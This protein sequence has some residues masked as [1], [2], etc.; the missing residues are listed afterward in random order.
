MTN[1]DKLRE[2]KINDYIEIPWK[3]MGNGYYLIYG[4]SKTKMYTSGLFFPGNNPTGIVK[5]SI[6]KFC[7]SNPKFRII[8]ANSK[9]ARSLEDKF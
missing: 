5:Q 4:K 9:K 3:E 6:K 1:Y 2:A 8:S 7:D